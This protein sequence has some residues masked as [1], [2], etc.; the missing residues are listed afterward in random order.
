MTV[1]ILILVVA[2][3]AIIVFGVIER[4]PVLLGAIL[5]LSVVVMALARKG[6]FR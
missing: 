5:T 1:Q 6:A 2:F 4:S 3:A